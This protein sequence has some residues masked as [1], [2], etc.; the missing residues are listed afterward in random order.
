MSA[1]RPTRLSSAW[2]RWA[3]TGST[4]LTDVRGVIADAL[5]TPPTPEEIDARSGRIRGRFRQFRRTAQRA[6]RIETGRRHRAGGRYSRS[7]GRARNGAER[8]PG[9]EVAHHARNRAG[10]HARFVHRRRHPRRLC[11]ARRCGGGRCRAS[12]RIAAPRHSRWVGAAGRKHDLLRRIA[13]RRRTRHGGAGRPARRARHGTRRFRQ[14]RESDPVV[15]QCRTGPGRG[16]GAFRR[17]SP[18]VRRR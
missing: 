16:Q 3:M 11:H 17:R 8:V 14:W 1:D 13:A 10:T 5:D 12:H 6:G 4:A 15:Q 18:R 2:R 9:H 7:R